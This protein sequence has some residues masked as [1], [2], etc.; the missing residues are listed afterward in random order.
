VKKKHILYRN[1]ES[2][3]VLALVLE[4]VPPPERK[5]TR[6][7]D[8]IDHIAVDQRVIVD[9]TGT[10]FSAKLEISFLIHEALLGVA[11]A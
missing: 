9:Y 5:T 7:Y 10:G 3:I 11:C 1:S 4:Q 6:E 2:E 8:E